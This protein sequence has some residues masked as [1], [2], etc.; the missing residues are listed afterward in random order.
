MLRRHAGAARFGFN[1]CLR[2]VKQALDR[3][4]RGA[5]GKV[6]WSG[7]D[8]I[9]AFNAWK[10][11]AAA[12]RVLVAAADGTTTVQTTGLAWRAEVCQQVFEEAAVDLGRGLAAYKAS[13]T[14]DR[15]GRRVG[16]PR[17]KSKK[18]APLSFRLRSRTSATGRVGIRVGDHGPRTVTLPGIGTM[19]VLEDT[20]R[21]RR[22]LA[23][24]RAKVL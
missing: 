2:L 21:L 12:G 15:R 23:K 8:L 9:N 10:A 16:F 1:Q 3:K 20:R 7:F 24:G 19:A 6:P 11:S 17:F 13:R 14:G 4:R 5:V 18:R 22:M